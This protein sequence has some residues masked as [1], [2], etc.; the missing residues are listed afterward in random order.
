MPV[1]LNSQA[2][3]LGQFDGAVGIAPFVVVPGIQLYLGAID[4]HGR[5]CIDDRGARVGAIIDGDQRALFKAKDALQ[6]AFGSWLTSSAVV[7][8]S[9][10]NTQSV[11]EA[12]ADSQG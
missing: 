10:S 5:Q 2:D 6:R 1:G 4:D 12:L 8:R 7:A 9:T 11:S 3:Q